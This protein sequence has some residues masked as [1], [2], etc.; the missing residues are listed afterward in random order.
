[1]IARASTLSL[2]IDPDG[3]FRNPVVRVLTLEGDGWRVALPDGLIARAH[4]AHGYD[5][6]SI[7]RGWIGE[8]PMTRPEDGLGAEVEPIIASFELDQSSSNPERMTS[9]SP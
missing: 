6:G 7:A 5:G 4:K 3:A 1:M 8:A 2:T 9:A